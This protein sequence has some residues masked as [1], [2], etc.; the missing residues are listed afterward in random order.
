[1]TSRY[2]TY[3]AW[4]GAVA[5][6]QTAVLGKIIWDRQSLL[7]TGREIVMQVQ[8]VDPR[9]LFRGE[10]VTLG[11]G[12][13]PVVSTAL[14]QS[15]SAAELRRGDP[16]FVTIRP[17]AEASWKAVAVSSVMPAAQPA[18]G[19]NG[20][21]VS[22][23]GRI[24]SV[25][26]GDTK[27]AVN[28]AVNFGIESYFVQEGRGK[29]LEQQVRDDKIQALVAVGPDGTAALKGLVIGGQ[30]HEDPSLF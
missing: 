2:Q 18:G 8:P 22:L 30:R 27:D 7:K 15:L 11:Y 19:P 12:I 26:P 9:D 16:V 5:L 21:D 6:V 13:S 28:F 14:S 10:Y 4:L 23:K 20:G 24:Q 1:M 29:L 25:W 3:F 17:D